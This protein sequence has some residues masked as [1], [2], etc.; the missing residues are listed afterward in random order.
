MKGSP[1]AAFAHAT[2]LRDSVDGDDDHAA[3]ATKAEAERWELLARNA[4]LEVN[5]TKPRR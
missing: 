4:R 2:A 1:E 3:R 5:L